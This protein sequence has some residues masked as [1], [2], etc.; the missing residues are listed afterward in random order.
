MVSLLHAEISSAA[1][2]T[3]EKAS[4]LAEI[5]EAQCESAP[6]LDTDR[7]QQWLE[8]DN[9]VLVLD[10]RGSLAFKGSHI[11]G[12]LN[13]PQETF[14]ELCENSIPIA[15]GRKILFVCP[16]GDQSR[17]FSAYFSRLGFDCASLQ[18]GFVAWRDQGKPTKK[19]R[20][21]EK[22]KVAL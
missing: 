22:C 15:E 4:A 3:E 6:S 14:E 5:D 16:V 13:I 2:W 19:G 18:G 1:L 7:A 9:N 12:A 21:R 10:L 11:E 20:R 17:K 8:S